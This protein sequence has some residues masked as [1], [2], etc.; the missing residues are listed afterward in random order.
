MGFFF[1]F[2]L[3][4]WKDACIN[5]GPLATGDRGVEGFSTLPVVIMTDEI[6]CAGVL[7][8]SP[9]DLLPYSHL[10]F[11]LEETNHLSYQ[12]TVNSAQVTVTED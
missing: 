2:P 4:C 9:F 7:F 10:L 3:H 6:I 8:P 5:S 12:I 1:F 11:V